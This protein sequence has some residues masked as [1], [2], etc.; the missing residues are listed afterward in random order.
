MTFMPEPRSLDHLLAQVAR[1]HHERARQQISALGLHRGQPHLIMSLKEEDGRTHTALAAYL[2][3]T[4]A[5]VTKMVQRMEHAGFVQ[6]Q[7]DAA[8]ERVSRVYLTA[9]GRET[10]TRL[11]D[12][13]ESLDAATFAGLTREERETLHGLLLRV[14]DNLLRG[15]DWPNPIV[16][17]D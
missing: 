13:F 15:T 16:N 2:H 5:T 7:A 10:G 4:P 17:E 3:V 11:D 12:L 9:A 14:R 6:R 8:D 1:L